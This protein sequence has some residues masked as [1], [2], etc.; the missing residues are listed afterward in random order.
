MRVLVDTPL[1]PKRA[2]SDLGVAVELQDI[3]IQDVT[4]TQPAP[5][6]EESSGLG[7]GAI[8]GIVVGVLAA[9]LLIAVLIFLA[10]KKDANASP[11]YV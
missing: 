4:T 3:N 11:D 2:S 1:T 6:S 5:E 8:A 10:A 7:A 9:L